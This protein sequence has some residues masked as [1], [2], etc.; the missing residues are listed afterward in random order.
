[1][2]DVIESLVAAGTTLLLT[3]QYLEEA[4]RLADEIVVIDHGRVIANGTADQ[5]KRQMG[6]ERL[7]ITVTDPS[8]LDDARAALA[9]L[10]SGP[11]AA[12]GT[13]RSL[14]VPITGGAAVLTDALRRLDAAGIVVDDVGLRRPTLDDVF[15]TLTGRGAEDDDGAT[16]AGG[17]AAH[18]SR[19][20][21]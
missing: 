17:P 18:D 19:R 21:G 6:G 13:P 7:E 2:W 4:D 8:R 9:P 11:V 14:V 15:L 16:P 12:G 1:M 20:T 10:G 3:T 5:L